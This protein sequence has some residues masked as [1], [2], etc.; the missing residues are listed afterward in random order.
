MQAKLVHIHMCLRNI[1]YG[2]SPADQTAAWGDR[3][4]VLLYKYIFHSVDAATSRVGVK[5]ISQALPGRSEG[6]G[7]PYF[8]VMDMLSRR[9]LL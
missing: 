5:V 1:M 9:S 8:L 6:L 3:F 7:C 4:L 2:G